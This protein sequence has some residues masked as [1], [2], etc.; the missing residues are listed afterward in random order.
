[1]KTDKKPRESRASLCLR[2]ILFNNYTKS[3][4]FLILL[5]HI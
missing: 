2:Y 1:M 5:I 4:Y 3:L